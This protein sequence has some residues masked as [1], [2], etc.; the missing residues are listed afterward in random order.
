MTSRI[1]G[2]L[3]AIASF[4]CGAD[5]DDPAERGAEIAKE[6][7]AAPANAEAIL[8]EHEMTI[9]EFEALMYEIAADPELSE[10]YQ[11]LL[12]EEE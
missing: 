9:D 5:S 7:Q 12:E 1:F 10:R 11:E 4:A 3:L 8:E 6:I 2:L